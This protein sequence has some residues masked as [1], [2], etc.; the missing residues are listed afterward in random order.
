MRDEPEI[1]NRLTVLAAQRAV[2]EDYMGLVQE[3]GDLIG[4]LDASAVMSEMDSRIE[5]LHWVLGDGK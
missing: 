1:R 3:R 5:A 4:V 2:L